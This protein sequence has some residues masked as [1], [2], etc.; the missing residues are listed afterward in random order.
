[1]NYYQYVEGE[2]FPYNEEEI[3]DMVKYFNP[4]MTIDKLK[5]IAGSYSVDDVVARHS[6]QN[7]AD[8]DGGGQSGTDAGGQADAGA[9]SDAE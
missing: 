1:M 8:A 7:Q 5:G 6:A 9:E 2:S 3:R 4:D